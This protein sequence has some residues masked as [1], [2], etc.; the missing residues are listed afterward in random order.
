[1]YDEEILI[2]GLSSDEV[3][4]LKELLRNRLESCFSLGEQITIE[5]LIEKLN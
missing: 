5:E 1:M 3:E 2:V 4:I